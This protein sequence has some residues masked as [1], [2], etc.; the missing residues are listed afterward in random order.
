MLLNGN[1]Y[2]FIKPSTSIFQGDPLSPL[3]SILCAEALVHIMNKA[4]EEK[5]IIGLR[6][7]KKFPLVQHLLFADDSMFLCKA[8]FKEGMKILQCLNLYGDASGQEINFLKSAITF[9]LGRGRG[10]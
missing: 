9:V 8:N 10:D 7:T 2:G 3:L 6:L 1:S 5:R 4:E